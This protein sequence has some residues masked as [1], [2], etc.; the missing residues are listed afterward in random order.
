MPKKGGVI[1]ST[2]FDEVKERTRKDA[3]E[4]IEMIVAGGGELYACKLAY[5]MFKLKR[6]D[7]D[8]NVSDVITV[9]QLYEMTGGEPG[10][11]I[12]FT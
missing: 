9:G 5:D 4:F 2:L 7:L 1:M 12:I 8:D 10:T 6:E 3:D 11:Q